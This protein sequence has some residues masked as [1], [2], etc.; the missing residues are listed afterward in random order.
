L[1]PGIGDLL[2]AGRVGWAMA[3]ARCSHRLGVGLTIRR[4]HRIVVPTAFNYV[5]IAAKHLVGSC[6]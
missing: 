2:G 3:V 4:I 1:R 6:G 5:A